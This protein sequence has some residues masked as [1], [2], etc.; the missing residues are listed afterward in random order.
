MIKL[1]IFFVAALAI[2]RAMDKDIEMYSDEMPKKKLAFDIPAM[3]KDADDF[4]KD[5]FN[6]EKKEIVYL[7]TYFFNKGYKKLPMQE[8]WHYLCSGGD[9]LFLCFI[10]IDKEKKVSVFVDVSLSDYRPNPDNL[11]YL[12]IKRAKFTFEKKWSYPPIVDY[13]N[14]HTV[15]TAEMSWNCVY[16][17]LNHMFVIC[18]DG[19]IPYHND[20]YQ[21]LYKDIETFGLDSCISRILIT[22]DHSTFVYHCYL[23]SSQV[24]EQK[25]SA[26]VS[27]SKLDKCS[28]I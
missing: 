2:V 13:W 27:K 22:R 12:S 20:M 25:Y 28:I 8:E 6:N 19:N 7:E 10:P 14:G 17:I 1:I 11:D 21:K 26:V 16:L 23:L 15:K 5:K 24:F 4:F 18:G 9:T 3:F